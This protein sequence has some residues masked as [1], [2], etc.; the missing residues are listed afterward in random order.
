MEITKAQRVLAEERAS[1]IQR[2]LYG[3]PESGEQLWNIASKYNLTERSTYYSFTQL[4]G[5]VV[6]GFYT[7]DQIGA[8]IANKLPQ[9]QGTTRIAL[10]AD[11]KIFLYPLTDPNYVQSVTKVPPVT[12]EL[13]TEISAMEREFASIERPPMT[14]ATASVY[15]SNTPQPEPLPKPDHAIHTMAQDMAALR[16]QQVTPTYSSNQADIL[17]RPI[18]APITPSPTPNNPPRW[19]S[20]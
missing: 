19:G 15:R 13:S 3:E 11:I 17:T 18:S 1:E 4:V 6:L 9:V 14:V 16:Q 8:L 10:E 20:E 7:Q 5:D 12:N 2:R